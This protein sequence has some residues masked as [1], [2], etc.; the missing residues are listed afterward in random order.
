MEAVDLGTTKALLNIVG[1]VLDI[2]G[3]ILIFKYGIN[4]SFK[5]C[6]IPAAK[7]Y[8]TPLK[9]PAIAGLVCVIIGFGLQVVA[10]AIIFL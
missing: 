5:W 6:G 3:V 4:I 2:I 7:P 1:L 9:K 10:N 8:E